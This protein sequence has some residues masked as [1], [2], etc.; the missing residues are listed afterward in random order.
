[1]GGGAETPVTIPTSGG[2]RARSGKK[3]GIA[4]FVITTCIMPIMHFP[5]I[6]VAWRW[7]D[8]LKLSSSVNIKYCSQIDVCKRD[9]KPYKLIFFS[10]GFV[11]CEV[12]FRHV[13]D[14]RIS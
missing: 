8:G 4:F 12:Q 11:V 3:L 14:Q 1:M 13:E 7:F 2:E 10:S 9:L 6:K 5:L